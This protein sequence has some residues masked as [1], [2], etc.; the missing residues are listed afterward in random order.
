MFVFI[1]NQQE[2]FDTEDTQNLFIANLDNSDM[3]LIKVNHEKKKKSQ[4]ML[5]MNRSIKMAV[6]FIIYTK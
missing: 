6:S 1:W 3:I 2:N 5:I 4:Q